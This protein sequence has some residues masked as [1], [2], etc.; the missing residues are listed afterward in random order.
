[1][2]LH[3]LSRP[4]LLWCLI[5]HTIQSTKLLEG[6]HV[7]ISFIIGSN[8][9]YQP[10]SLLFNYSLPLYEDISGFIFMIHGIHLSYTAEVIDERHE[11]LRGPP[12]IGVDIIHNSKYRMTYVVEAHF[13]LFAINTVPIEI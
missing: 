8:N 2:V 3:S 11:V 10:P 6:I 7:I 5:H 1:M 13:V 4:I 12:Y 9:I